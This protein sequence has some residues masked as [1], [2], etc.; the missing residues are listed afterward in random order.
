[1]GETVTT[2]VWGE[3]PLLDTWVDCRNTKAGWRGRSKRDGRVH[4]VTYDPRAQLVPLPIARMPDDYFVMQKDG[5]PI[6][7]IR[8]EKRVRRAAS[9]TRR[10]AKAAATVVRSPRRPH[11]R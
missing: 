11:A 7:A 4:T 8:I 10:R 3:Q 2:R 5:L 6:G 9:G 1:M